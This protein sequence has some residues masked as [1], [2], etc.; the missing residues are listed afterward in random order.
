M[1]D[2]NV[3][4]PC[5]GKECNNY[6]PLDKT[7]LKITNLWRSAHGAKTGLNTA[8]H[9]YGP[10]LYGAALAVKGGNCRRDEGPVTTT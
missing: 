7:D 5:I 6:H 8:G 10:G 4:I 1:E 2:N 3:V 9:C